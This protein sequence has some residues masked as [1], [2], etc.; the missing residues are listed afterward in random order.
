MTKEDKQEKVNL[1]ERLPN[2]TTVKRRQ[3]R[4]VMGMT[5]TLI[6]DITPRQNNM[7]Q[8]E[9]QLLASSSGKQLMLNEGSHNDTR[10][11]MSRGTAALLRVVELLCAID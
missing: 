7:H 10:S 3:E 9:R 4:M 11:T 8:M 5:G 6:P 1:G 2:G